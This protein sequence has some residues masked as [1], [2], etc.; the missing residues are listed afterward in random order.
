MPRQAGDFGMLLFLAALAMLFAAS[1]LAYLI[2]RV[3]KTREVVDPSSPDIVAYPATAPALHSIHLPWTLAIS[4]VVIL[5]SSFTV[6]A[7]LRNV[8]RERQGKFRAWLITTLGL[9]IAFLLIQAPSLGGL[10]YEHLQLA[11]VPGGHTMLGLIFVLILLHALHVLGGIIPLAVVTYRAGQ[12]RYDHE[13]HQPVRNVAMYWHFLDGV[14]IVMYA[15][16][17]LAG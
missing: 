13:S 2:V 16:L 4:T 3:T 12:D 17:W 9:S 1:M 5:A 6:S 7:A 14:W 10:L 11:E 8:R 15:V